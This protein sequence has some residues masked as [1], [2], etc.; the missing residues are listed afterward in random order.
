MFKYG[1]EV[2]IKGGF[3]EDCTGTLED[4]VLY[5]DGSNEYVLYEVR[6][7]LCSSSVCNY[8]IVKFKESN[9][10]LIKKV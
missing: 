5:E 6:L 3:F 7:R 4:F 2:R 1:N 9:I 10:E 8:R